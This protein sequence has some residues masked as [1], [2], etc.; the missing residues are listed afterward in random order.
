MSPTDDTHDPS[1]GVRRRHFPSCAGEEVFTPF[2]VYFI[3]TKDTV[4]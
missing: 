2:E 1:A 4:D 3:N